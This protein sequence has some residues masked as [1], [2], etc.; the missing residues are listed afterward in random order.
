MSSSNQSARFEG[1]VALVTGAG[2]G[3]GKAICW[4][5]AREGAHVA[6]NDVTYDAADGTARE[7]RNCGFNAVAVAA[8]V[9]DEGAVTLMVAEVIRRLGTLDILVNNAALTM[10]G[11]VR[12]FDLQVEDWDR[13]F[14]VNSRGV[15]L[16]ILAAA[17][18]MSPGSAIVNISS[19]GASRA[20]R[21][22][23]GY[24]SAKGAVEALTRATSLELAPFGIRVNA[25]APGALLTHRFEGLSHDDQLQEVAPIPLGRT[26]TGEDVAA[27]VAFLASPDAAYITGQVLTIDGGLTVQA[28]ELASETIR[29]RPDPL[30]DGDK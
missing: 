12:L 22:A 7:L 9:A 18:V 17:R 16:C 13:V 21:Y 14:A 24:D 2:R 8:D 1:K 26:G 10:V 30:S 20:H 25:V 27:A 3:V 11:R 4:R 15:F 6:V 19:I 5:L 29:P 28:R 23:T